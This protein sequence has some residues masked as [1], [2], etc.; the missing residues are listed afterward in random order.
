VGELPWEKIRDTTKNTHLLGLAKEIPAILQQARA[1]NTNKLYG[2]AYNRWKIWTNNYA[3]ITPLPAQPSHV[4]LYLI[5][6]EKSA[7]TYSVINTALCAISWA[8]NLAGLESPTRNILV[9]EISNGLKRRLAR[10]PQPKEPFEREHIQQLIRG[11]ECNNLT[12]I[13]NTLIIVIAY[14]AFLRVDELRHVRSTHLI[15]SHDHVKIAIPKSKCDQLR[16]GN[17]VL[18][19]RLGGELCPVALLENY[20]KQAKVDIQSSDHKGVYIFRRL[21]IT[22]K[23]VEKDIPMSY[24]SVTDLVKRKATQLGLN[25]NSFGTHSMRIGGATTAANSLIPDRLFQKHGRWASASSK[26]RYVKDS[27]QQRMQISQALG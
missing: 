17:S 27:Q 13:R 22:N 19:A 20:L 6:L 16:Q 8:H 4:I 18:V 12:D 2:Q 23:L 1:P 9:T 25:A 11:M 7:K 21:K 3:E 26:D 14:F 15:I 5:H 24:S 10:P